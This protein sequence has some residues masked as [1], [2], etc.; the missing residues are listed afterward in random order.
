MVFEIAESRLHR[1]SQ[2]P[3]CIKMY[4]IASLC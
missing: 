2:W 4:E 1:D 3:R